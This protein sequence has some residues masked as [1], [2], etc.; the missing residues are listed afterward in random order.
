[1]TKN[2]NE[3]RNDASAFSVFGSVEQK[4]RVILVLSLLL[5]ISLFMDYQA[6]RHYQSNQQNQ[7]KAQASARH[8]PTFAEDLEEAQAIL[9]SELTKQEQE[10]SEKA[11]VKAKAQSI[12]SGFSELKES[13]KKAANNQLQ[14]ELQKAQVSPSSAANILTKLE[15]KHLAKNTAPPLD[16][17]THQGKHYSLHFIRFSAKKSQIVAVKRPHT[18]AK[19][20][21]GRVLEQLRNGPNASEKGLLN[22]FDRYIE[23]K[24]ISL[25]G[26]TAVINV[27]S[28]IGRLGP[29]VIHDRLEQ[30]T[31]TLTQFRQVD[32]VQILV[33]D[34]VPQYIGDAQVSIGKN[35]QT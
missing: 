35:P 20:R 17:I 34:K 14:S 10:V 15:A 30:L 9:A 8:N 25:A 29:H 23:I 16:Q 5:V 2:V 31:H 27:N 12:V 26:R 33:N 7:N 22:N 3:L 28:A 4:N 13:L 1:M 11:P 24:G 21:L 32:N 6:R 18:G 19:L